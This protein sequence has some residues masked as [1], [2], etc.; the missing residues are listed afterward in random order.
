MRRGGGTAFRLARPLLSALM[1]DRLRQR[2]VQ[3]VAVLSCVAAHLEA[4]GLGY[5][6]PAGRTA[7]DGTCRL[8][9]GEQE[10]RYAQ[11]RQVY[12]DVLK[13]WG[14]IIPLA[15][16]VKFGSNTARSAPAG[17]PAA[18]GGRTAALETSSISGPPNGTIHL[19]C[20]PAP[21]SPARRPRAHSVG[22]TS[23]LAS[24]PNSAAPHERG[25]QACPSTSSCVSGYGCWYVGS[26]EPPTLPTHSGRGS[27]E[28]QDRTLCAVCHLRVRGLSW[29]CGSCGHGGHLDCM[30]RWMCSDDACGV[31]PAGCGCCCLHIQPDPEREPHAMPFVDTGAGV[32]ARAMPRGR[33]SV[34]AS[35]ASTLAP[36]PAAVALSATASPHRDA[37]PRS[38]VE[39]IG[40]T[41]RVADG[42]GAGLKASPTS[43]S[44]SSP[45]PARVAASS[46]TST[47]AP[48]LLDS[49][50]SNLGQLL[51]FGP[52]GNVR[53]TST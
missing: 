23:S 21:T 45:I 5:G 36:A 42:A 13:R 33:D 20:V 47:R 26:S 3:T 4:A 17:R 14:L 46:S 49:L 37:L 39:G 51:R 19:A 8:L 48:P 6:W 28:A 24:A 16:L 30:R 40:A 38:P 32:G 15:E 11:C 9:P 7:V 18:P 43:A 50:S 10:A 53:T 27:A 22:S 34:P 35:P 41:D 2:D 44:I 25:I 12:A 1:L 52:R 29:Y 31:C